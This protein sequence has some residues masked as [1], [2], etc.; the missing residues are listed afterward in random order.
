[1]ND[2]CQPSSVNECVWV[3]GVYPCIPHLVFTYLNKSS[4][5]GA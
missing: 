2:I 4:R 3:V 1:M 5:E